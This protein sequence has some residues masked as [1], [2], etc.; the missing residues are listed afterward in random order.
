MPT[1]PEFHTAARPLKPWL[2]GCVLHTAPQTPVPTATLKLNS[3][4]VSALLDSGSAIPLVCPSARPWTTQHYESLAVTCMH[5]DEREISTAQ[6]QIAKEV[7]S[8]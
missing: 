7:S 4:L 5:M 6:V 2:V 3:V 8:L 1:E